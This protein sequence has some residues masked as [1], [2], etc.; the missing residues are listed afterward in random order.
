ML[1]EPWAWILLCAIWK[2]SGQS[3]AA[4]V[5]SQNCT[6]TK[7]LVFWRSEI[8][9]TQSRYRRGCRSDKGH[10]EFAFTISGVIDLR[11]FTFVCV[12]SSLVCPGLQERTGCDS[13]R[14]RIPSIFVVS[15]NDRDRISE[16][17]SLDNI[18]NFTFRSFLLI[19]IRTI[20]DAISWLDKVYAMVDP[21]CRNKR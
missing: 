15:G 7:D 3:A 11:I 18:Q 6:G 16:A 1:T 10:L 14:V 2:C 21:C 8:L 17:G 13:K 4:D 9:A 20:S 5:Q 12:S 19:S